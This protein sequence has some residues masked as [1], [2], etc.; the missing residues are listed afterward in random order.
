VVAEKD[1]GRW[2]ARKFPEFI[3][4]DD[5]DPKPRDNA[6]FFLGSI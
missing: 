3:V 1:E 6:W 5:F 2:R 4:L